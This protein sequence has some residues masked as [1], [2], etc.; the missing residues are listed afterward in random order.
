MRV[1]QGAIVQFPSRKLYKCQGSLKPAGGAAEWEAAPAEGPIG[2]EQR[3]RMGCYK[4][5][6]LLKD[7]KGFSTNGEK[8]VQVKISEQLKGRGYFI[9]MN[10]LRREW[11]CEN[12]GCPS[13]TQQSKPDKCESQ[14][15]KKKSWVRWGRRLGTCSHVG[16]KDRRTFG[17]SM[18]KPILQHGWVQL[19]Y[20]H[21]VTAVLKHHYPDCPSVLHRTN[22]HR[23]SQHGIRAKYWEI[24]QA[25]FLSG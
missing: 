5:A 8:A 17:L 10:C 23:H 24:L 25:S 1:G 2:W 20:C 12:T 22:Q 14:G 4:Q 13:D 19:N 18:R 21:Y 11:W 15:K 16:R 3:D 6:M 7:Q 9:K